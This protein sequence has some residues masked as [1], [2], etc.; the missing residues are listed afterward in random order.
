MAL[1]CTYRVGRADHPMSSR[2][3][4]LAAT[5][6][7]TTR[8]AVELVSGM[9]E[10]ELDGPCEDSTVAAVALHFAAGHQAMVRWLRSVLDG[11]T[12][13]AGRYPRPAAPRRASKAAILSA[14]DHGAPAVVMAL[15]GLTDEQ[16]DLVTPPGPHSDGTRTIVEVFGF[17]D[18]HRR[19]HLDNIRAAARRARR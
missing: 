9:T 14:L 19:E 13:P 7:A 18:G 2:S 15:G 6:E 4:R 8:D 3:T 5:F 16:L 1:L 11:Q 12:T 10:S 17:I